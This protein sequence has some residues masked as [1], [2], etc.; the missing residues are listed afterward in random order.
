MSNPIL[1]P[2]A[3]TRTHTRTPRESLSASPVQVAG[4][5]QFADLQDAVGQARAAY[6]NTRALALALSAFAFAANSFI[7]IFIFIFPPSIAGT[8]PKPFAGSTPAAQRARQ[9]RQPRQ[10]LLARGPTRLRVGWVGV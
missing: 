1:P 9:Q 7:F 3:H 4:P 6:P 8:A 5:G 2:P 10:Q